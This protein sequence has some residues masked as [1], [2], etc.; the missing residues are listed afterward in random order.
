MSRSEGDWVCGDVSD[1]TFVT[2][3]IKENQA[4]YIFHLAANST[5][6]HAALVENY[7]TI[8]TGSIAILEAVRKSSPHSKVFLTGSGVQ[9]KN[10]GKAIAETDEFDPINAYSMARIQS[11]YAAR[12]FRSLGLKIYVG[13]LFHHESVFRKQNHVSQLIVETVRRIQQGSHEML[14]IG[15]LTVQKEWGYAADI[16]EGIFTLIQQNQVFEATIGT[17]QAH[18]IQEWVSLCFDHIGLDWQGLRSP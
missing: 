6:K 12:Y 2:K 3:L 11:V 14:E 1:F 4:D 13:Y 8:T 18:T 7:Q 5:T 10:T 17:G 15:D 16:A 9:F